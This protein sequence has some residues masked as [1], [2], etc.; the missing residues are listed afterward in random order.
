MTTFINRILNHLRQ[1]NSAQ[2]SFYRREIDNQDSRSRI[3]LNQS[4]MVFRLP[5]QDGCDNRFERMTWMAR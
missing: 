1:Q 5:V 3:I 2:T 4:Q